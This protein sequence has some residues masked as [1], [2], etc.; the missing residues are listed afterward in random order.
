V[1]S[2]VKRNFANDNKLTLLFKRS[3]T[4]SLLGIRYEFGAATFNDP[5]ARSAGCALTIHRIESHMTTGASVCRKSP[6]YAKSG[7]R[8]SAR[9]F[10]IDRHW[11]AWVAQI[12]F[13]I[14]AKVSTIDVGVRVVSL[15]LKV[16]C[17][18]AVLALP[19]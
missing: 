14:L 12:L 1:S 5:Y 18:S 4:L 16:N 9:R 7:E 2:L 11:R 17:Q 10:R 13:R 19:E 15:A 8:E 3:V 6:H